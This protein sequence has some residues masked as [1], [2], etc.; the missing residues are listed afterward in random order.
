[1]NTKTDVI[2]IVDITDSHALVPNASDNPVVTANGDGTP[3]SYMTDL[4][5]DFVGEQRIGTGKQTYI[6]FKSIDDRLRL[7]IQKTVYL[8]HKK[9]AAGIGSLQ[10]KIATLSVIAQCLGTSDW[11]KLDSKVYFRNFKVVLKGRRYKRNGALTRVLTALNE[12]HDLGVISLIID[13]KN[14]KFIKEMACPEAVNG[15][16]NVA[17]PETMAQKLFGEAM[18]I[19]EKCHPYRHDISVAYSKAIELYNDV[20]DGNKSIYKRNKAARV[21]KGVKKIKH[22]IPDFRLG[23]D[24]HCASE[25]QTACMLVV[26]GFSGVRFGEALSF[27]K[28]SYDE[29]PYSDNVKISLLQ[30]EITKLNE[31]GLPA[32][33]AWVTHPIAKLALELAYDSTEYAREVYRKKIDNYAVDQKEKSERD[34]ESAFITIDCITQKTAFIPNAG[35]CS[36]RFRSFQEK[37]NITASQ[38]D[39]DEFNLLNPTRKDSLKVSGF[40]QKLS[41]HDFRRT[42]AVFLVRNKLGSLVNLKWQYKHDNIAMS[43]WYSNHS[44]LAAQMDFEMDTELMDM[45]KEANEEMNVSILYEIYNEAE[46]LSGQQGERVLFERNSKLQDGEYAG[47]V[48]M[49]REE[50][51]SQ[52]RNG[53]LSIV[54]HPTGYCAKPTCNRICASDRSAVTCQHEIVTADKA[55]SRISVRVRLIETFNSMNDG[56]SYMAS[57]LSDIYIRIRS[58]EVTLKKHGLDFTP[59]EAEI[60]SQTMLSEV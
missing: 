10:N 57:I 56:K 52:V 7:D 41:N 37:Y 53:S 36:R 6:T 19:V 44:D 5:W 59:F 50:I 17:I 45:V 20:W 1:M 46:T 34:I 9:K 26:L 33:E 12:F 4:K 48:Y 21:Q 27:N 15:Q 2:S 24:F 47:E 3:C 40:L 39:V 58:I 16:Q 31:K 51:Q 54:E 25:I 30:G 43:A 49:S 60:Q 8:M 22:S 38:N 29:I 18:S 28:D 55:K 42:F 11:S 35:N 23:L 14:N 32:R 13:N